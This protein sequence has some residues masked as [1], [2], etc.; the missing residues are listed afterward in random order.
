[1]ISQVILYSQTV[2]FLFIWDLKISPGD[3]EDPEVITRILKYIDD[4]KILAKVKECEDVATLQDKLEEVYLWESQ[5]NMKYNGDKFMKLW[6]GRLEIMEQ[7]TLYTPGFVEPIKMVVLA[8]DLGIMLDWELNF[9]HQRNRAVTK[10]NNKASWILRTFRTRMPDITRI[11]WHSL[12]LPHL[13]YCSILWTP[14]SYKGDLQRN[15]KPN[16]EIR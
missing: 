15:E 7:T 1:M 2:F 10:A 13:D 3:L 16:E 4:I 6:V 14:L 12:V 8:K 11:A 5:N 9:K